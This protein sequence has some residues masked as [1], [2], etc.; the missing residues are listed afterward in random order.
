ME[1]GKFQENLLSFLNT[2]IETLQDA[3]KEWVVK[4][5]IDI[6]QNIYTISIDTKIISK[7][8]ELLLSKEDSDKIAKQVVYR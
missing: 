5:F 1:T 6:Y 8:I 2:R 4:G 3:R 7:I